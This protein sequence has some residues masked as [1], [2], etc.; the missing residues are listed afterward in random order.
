MSV[1]RR[2]ALS[3]DCLTCILK[4]G[5]DFC[6]LPRDPLARL[7]EM[8]HISLFPAD[9]V[10]I[11]EGQ[12]PRGVF[13]ICSGSAKL[14]L[15]ARDGKTVILKIARERQVMGLS[16]ALSGRPSPV[17][18]TTVE[19]SQ[20]KF[21]AQESLLALMNEKGLALSCAQAL[22][23]EVQSAFQ[24]VYELLV[25]DFTHEEMAQM[26][27]SSRETVTRLLSDM[28]RRALIRMEGS[29]LIIPD[30]IALQAIAA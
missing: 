29:I 22:G 28:K 1:Q 15:V 3:D 4:C 8:G 11:A 19:P 20:V 18:V 9:A 24:D 2:Y 16:A 14:S 7:S 23:R 13:V 10:L 12:V 25:S 21:V 30:R 17:T 27:G 5:P 26:I 6:N